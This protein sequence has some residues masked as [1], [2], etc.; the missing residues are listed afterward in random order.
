M[1]IEE[2][3]KNPQ[4]RF[5]IRALKL[6][7]PFMKDFSIDE[8]D[9]NKYSTIFIRP[10]IDAKEVTETYGWKIFN[11]VFSEPMEVRPFGAIF[12]VDFD[13]YNEKIRK[14]IEDLVWSINHSEAVPEEFRLKGR[15]IVVMDYKVK[16]INKSEFDPENIQFYYT[17]K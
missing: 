4:F 12:D 13:E 7:F 1:T 15:T 11:W 8:E 16:P 17:P 10:I 5:T 2:L 14:P 6:K 3:K 9:L